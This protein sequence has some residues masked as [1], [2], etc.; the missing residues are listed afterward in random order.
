MRPRLLLPFLLFFTYF[1]STLIHCQETTTDLYY[2]GEYGRVLEITGALI[3]SGD[4]AFNTFYLQV[5]SEVQLGLTARA[6]EFLQTALVSHPGNTRLLRMLAGQQFEAGYYVRSQE[7]FLELV[8]RDSLDVSSWFRLAEI[9]SFRQ[10]NDRA[11]ELLE[12]VLEID[13]LHMESL[14]M[15][16]EIL[17]RDNNSGAIAYY[18]KAWRHY[19]DNQ[20]AAYALANLKIQ[21]KK[22]WEALPV[23]EHILSTDSTNIKFR[24][25]KGYAHYKTGEPYAAIEAFTRAVKLGDSTAFTFKYKGIS[26][27]LTADF[28]GAIESLEKAVDRD[29]SDA[30]NHFFL[31][32]SLAT[33]TE[34]ER[35]MYHLNRSLEL[36]RP[37]PAIVSRIYSEEGNIKRLEMKYEEA[38]ELYNKAFEADTLNP[39]ALYFMASILDNSLHRSQ[40]ALQVY[41]RYIDLLNQLPEKDHSGQGASIRTIVEDRIIALKEELF[42]LDEQ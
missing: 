11:A 13:S 6:I 25:L 19:P 21:Q 14:M 36:M 7:G 3:Q 30:E 29:T 12:K 23:C 27:Y 5:L 31:G 37:D 32:A 4:T 18:E 24:K 9:A 16:G 20:K 34:K 35:A 41:E 10:Q 8:K 42:F 26:Q 38:Y 22:A 1:P 33:T 40:E 17:N 15:M 2:S 28:P 39:L